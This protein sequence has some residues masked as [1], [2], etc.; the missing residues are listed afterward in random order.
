M[1]DLGKC[2]NT[3]L[4]RDTTSLVITL[5]ISRSVTGLSLKIFLLKNFNGL[6]SRA[7]TT[8]CGEL[9]RFLIIIPKDS[10]WVKKPI[11]T[12]K[13]TVNKNEIFKKN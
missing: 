11:N 10:R 1:P 7:P 12:V 4:V 3:L 9:R 5:K 13:F 8:K 2:H 6:P